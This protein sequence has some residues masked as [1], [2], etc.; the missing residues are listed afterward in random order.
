MSPITAVSL[1]DL[2]VGDDPLV[3]LAPFAPDREVKRAIWQPE[4]CAAGDRD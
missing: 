4:S 3:D 2:I 1:A